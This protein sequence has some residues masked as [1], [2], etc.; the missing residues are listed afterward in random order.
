MANN[1]TGNRVSPAAINAAAKA[2]NLGASLFSKKKK[3]KPQQGTTLVSQPGAKSMV[4]QSGALITTSPPPY[5]FLFAT[6]N[7]GNGFQFM[8]CPWQTYNYSGTGG[9][10][11]WDPQLALDLESKR[12]YRVEYA[13]LEFLGTG[14]TTSTLSV[15]MAGSRNPNTEFPEIGEFSLVERFYIGPIY[16]PGKRLVL[17][18]DSEWHEIDTSVTTSA[19]AA[20]KRLFTAGVGFVFFDGAVSNALQT[21][22]QLTMK[23]QFRGR[24]PVISVAPTVVSRTVDDP[25][26]P[27]LIAVPLAL[28]IGVPPVFTFEAATLPAAGKGWRTRSLNPGYYLVSAHIVTTDA[29]LAGDTC[30]GWIVADATNVDVTATQSVD[31]VAAGIPIGTACAFVET[32][33]VR[34]RQGDSLCLPINL[35]NTAAV[36]AWRSAITCLRV[37]AATALA[38]YIQDGYAGPLPL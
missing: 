37:S 22:F 38:K 21:K 30:G 3:K 16:E 10:I 17:P 18:H 15:Y 35:Q 13:E 6:L 20:N 32:A 2:L 26:E 9:V 23:L 36:G 28:G 1:M 5:R 31:N 34:L 7:Q 11:G 29:Y 24:D 27:G 4:Q 19:S 14:P 12:E 8:V 33:I 25:A